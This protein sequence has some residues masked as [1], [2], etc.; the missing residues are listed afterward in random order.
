MQAEYVRFSKEE[1]NYGYKNLLHS[2][3]EFLNVMRSFKDYKELRNKEFA[4]KVSLKSKIG[5]VLA[6][7]ENFDGILPKTHM[8]EEVHKKEKIKKEI[9]RKPS[10]DM[11]D[12]IKM[13]KEKL[14][15][16]QKEM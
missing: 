4:L 14:Y 9:K 16:L 6:D 10:D 12:E 1:R 3:L 8:H 13:I 5:E 15:N 7:I 11:F 2:E